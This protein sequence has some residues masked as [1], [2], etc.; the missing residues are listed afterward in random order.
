MNPARQRS[1]LALLAYRGPQVIGY[2]I[3][4]ATTIDI[5]ITHSAGTD[6]NPLTDIKGFEVIGT[7]VG[8]IMN[9]VRRD[10]VK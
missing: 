3:V 5:H 2:E 1:W 6:I 8:E 4:D 10:L 9:A 7:G